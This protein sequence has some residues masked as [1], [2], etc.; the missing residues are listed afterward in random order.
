MFS[1]RLNQ[2]M[3]A[4]G[5][6]NSELARYAGFDRTNISRMRSGT[7]VPK[8]TSASLSK[9]VQGIGQLARDQGKRALLVS[10]T[11][12]DEAADFEQGLADWLLEGEEISRNQVPSTGTAGPFYHFG[13]KLDAIMGLV[14]MTNVKL[15][16]KLNVD[17]SLISRF[18]SG[19]RSPKSN[20]ALAGRLCHLLY[21]R[22]I[23]MGRQ[24]A[25][26]RLM[27]VTVPEA[28][29]GHFSRWLCDFDTFEADWAAAADRLLTAF[30]ADL[31]EAGEGQ[32][33]PLD[34]VMPAVAD[35]AQPTFY[36][37]ASGFRAAVLCFLRTALYRNA[38]RLWLYSDQPMDWLVSD[39]AF[40]TKWTALMRA[41]VK[42]GTRIRMIHSI[43]RGLN[44]MQAAIRSWLP[45]YMSG[46]MEPYYRTRSGDG[47]FSHTFFYCPGVA[48]V[49]AC[50]VA[51][52]EA[53]GLYHY[54]E[55]ASS[56]VSVE[57][58]YRG[59]FAQAK[60]LMRIGETAACPM[61]ESGVTVIQSGPSLATMPED[62]AASFGSEALMAAWRKQQK[63]YAHWLQAG[64]VCEYWPWPSDAA[65][66]AGQ[67]RVAAPLNGESM[68]Y[69]AV[70]IRGTSASSES[71]LQGPCQLLFVYPAGVALSPG[72]TGDRLGH[73]AGDAS[74]AAIGDFS[75]QSSGN[76]PG[77]SGLCLSDGSACASFCRRKMG[78]KLHR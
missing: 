41:C 68:V 74:V 55:E 73:D 13:E 52:C 25:L 45:L 43:D 69:Y 17:A 65:V 66:A 8:A 21:G 32:M 51:G 61:P 67:I 40:H 47:A 6:N 57:R 53:T 18:R 59:L 22:V 37:G 31:S 27:G 12:Q 34:A 3:A 72:E 35:G 15:S 44:E 1:E 19:A 70:T 56:L 38:K 78:M 48:A 7:R 2:L 9:L 64:Y 63:H 50:H 62:L 20:S 60:P 5:T 36:I 30:D 23:T 71:I 75:A 16:Q 10:V 49:T 77:V 29:E 26:A 11:D 39:S 58:A 46:M 42:R 14:E 28:D 54:H 4:L 76:V 24:A 33:P